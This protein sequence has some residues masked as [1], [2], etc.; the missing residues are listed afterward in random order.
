MTELGDG[1]FQKCSALQNVYLS[2]RLI[3][4]GSRAFKSSTAIREI[5]CAAETPPATGDDVFPTEI[6]SFTT[7]SVPSSSQSDYSAA[8]VWKEFMHV[9]NFNPGSRE[10]NGI[11]YILNN[12]TETA[13]VTYQK[14]NDMSN[15]QGLTNVVI[16]ETIE[17]NDVTY[18]IVG[19]GPEAFNYCWGLKSISLPETIESIDTL[20]FGYC[21]SLRSIEIPNSVKTIGNEAFTGCS[22]LSSASI[23]EAV[24]SIGDYGFFGCTGLSEITVPQSVTHIGE[25]AFMGVHW[26]NEVHAESIIP[27]DAH[28]TAFSTTAYKNATLY[29]PAGTLATYQAHPTWSKFLNMEVDNGT[30]SIDEIS[31]DG[32]IE[33]T[34]HG[35]TI[36]ISGKDDTDVAMVYDLDGRLLLSTTDSVFTVNT[37]SGVVVVSIN[38]KAYKI[39]LR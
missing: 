35:T 13:M 39:A 28:A 36:S 23:G 22:A 19:V 16:P 5:R 3:A 31:R 11:Y 14:Q 32:E 38:G 9:D 1:F 34:A 4:I 29:V 10:I 37:G 21:T 24:E 27:S 33:V 2:K 6:Y 26:L 18:T 12:S 30:M 15:Y 25:Y 8:A 20:A 17:Y 7:L